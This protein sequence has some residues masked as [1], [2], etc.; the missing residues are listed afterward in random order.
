MTGP[1]TLPTSAAISDPRYLGL[2]VCPALHPPSVLFPLS[3]P[4]LPAHVQGEDMS[5]GGPGQGWLTPVL[6]YLSIASPFRTRSVVVE[7]ISW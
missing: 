5:L 4:A 7:T 6:V 1:D 3:F 2:H